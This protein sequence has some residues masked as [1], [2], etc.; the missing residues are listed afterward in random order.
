MAD[1]KIKAELDLSN[2]FTTFISAANHEITADEPL[3]VGG[4]DQ[5]MSPYQ[6][7][8]SALASCTVMTIKMYAERKEWPVEKIFV[9]VEHSKEEIEGEIKKKDVFE[10]RIKF[11]GEL[12]EKQITRLLQIAEK[13][14]VNRTLKASSDTKTVLLD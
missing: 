6:L 1:S 5:G 9:E 2:G 14:P 8:N 13:C 10:K 11:F 12:T 7:L 3:S 4:S